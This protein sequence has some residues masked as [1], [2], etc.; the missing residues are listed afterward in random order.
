M[1]DFMAYRY[2]KVNPELRWTAMKDDL[3]FLKRYRQRIAS[4]LESESDRGYAIARNLFAIGF[5][6]RLSGF[7]YRLG[8]A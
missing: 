1:R 2:E 3:P 4:I 6:V 8:A 5:F 7:K